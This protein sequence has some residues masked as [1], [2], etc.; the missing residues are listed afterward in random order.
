[1]PIRILKP[2]LLCTV[3]DL[4]RP[5]YQSDGIPACGAMDRYS[6]RL[7]NMLCGNEPGAAVLETAWHGAQWITESEILLAFCGGGAKWQVNDGELPSGRPVLVPAFSVISLVPGSR[8]F[9]S[10]LAAAGGF[11]AQVHQGS[12]S[13]YIPARMGGYQGRA[14]QVGDVLET[15]ALKTM[16]AQRMVASLKS[17]GKECHYPG[18]GIEVEFD[19][20][21]VKEIRILDGPEADWFELN[22]GSG[23]QQETFAISVQSNR[24]ATRLEGKKLR[25]CEK[26]ELL[27]TAVTRGTVQVTHDGS[28]LVLM[29]DA[30]TTGGYPR[31]AQVAAADLPRIAQLRPGDRIRLKRISWEQAEDLYLEEERKL[32]QLERSIAMRFGL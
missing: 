8:G 9:Y 25:A 5:G 32:K 22:P 4:G 10:Y 15:G 19:P 18:W 28:L 31:I 23:L 11:R 29:A 26:R 6:M 21:P 1:M 14:L 3:Q 30:Q 13:T 20:A 7:A 17:S 12:A 27:S 16:L 2:G 24:M